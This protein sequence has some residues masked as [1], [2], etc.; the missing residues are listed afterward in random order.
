[1]TK[2]QEIERAIALLPREEFFRLVRHLR[3]RHTGER[4]RAIEE[5]AQSGKLSTSSPTIEYC[6]ATCSS[7]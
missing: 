7:T 2:L 5:D 6:V 4:D 1:V 3:E